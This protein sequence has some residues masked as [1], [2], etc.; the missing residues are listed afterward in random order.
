MPVF[1]TQMFGSGAVSAYEISKSCIFADAGSVVLTRTQVASPTDVKIWTFSCWIKRCNLNLS[2]GAVLLGGYD[3]GSGAQEHIAFS[4]GA[5]GAADTLNLYAHNAGA[6]GTDST[7][8]TNALFRDV[9][10]WYHLV[11]IK[12]TT[13]S[14]AANREKLYVNGVQQTFTGTSFPSLNF[15]TGRINLGSKAQYLCTW[16]NTV[17]NY[18]GYM[19]EA[20]FIDG[21]AKVVG[22]FGET[23]DDGVWIPI[24]YTGGSYGNN[25]F[26]LD[27]KSSGD[28]G[29]DVSGNNNDFSTT[30]MDAA[31]QSTDTPTDNHCTLNSADNLYSGVALSDG[32]KSFTNTAGAQHKAKGTMYPSSGKWYWEVKW[33]SG[34]SHG[35]VGLAQN[36]VISQWDMGDNRG[37]LTGESLGY[38]SYDGNTYKD[39]T[40][41][42]FGDSWT[43]GDIISVAWDADNGK[44][45]FGKNNTWQNSGDPTS[46]AT[47]TG[48]AYSLSS[49]V[50]AGGGWGPAVCNEGSSIFE[51]YFAE[52]EWSYSAPTGYTA[53]S[54]ANMAI[55]ALKDP[56]TNF[57]AAIYTG[58]GTAIG[59][60]GNAV[61][62]DGNS[63]MQP[64]IVWIKNRSAAD[65]HAN[66]DAARGVTKELHINETDAETTVAEGV[67]TFGSDGFTVGSDVGVN[68]NT[69][70]Y[71][72]WNWN[73]GNSGSSNTAGTI[74]T[75]T[76]YVDAT[77]GISVSTFEGNGTAGQTVGHGL[78]VKPDMII[79]KNRDGTEQWIVYHTA[80]GA[81]KY[82]L[83]N[84]NAA[85][86]TSNGAWNDV[87]PTTTLV[88][89]GGGGFGTNVSSNSMIMYAFAEVSGFSKFG[90]YT[91]NGSTDGPFFYCGFSPELI[92]V[93]R[94]DSTGYWGTWDASRETYNPR[95]DQLFFD[96]SNAEASN[97]WQIDFSANGAKIRDASAGINT[98]GG[99]YIFMAFA[100]NP[101]GGDGVA[102]ATAR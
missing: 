40:L 76:T 26:Y 52:A 81:T 27:F 50:T 35:Q 24:E 66:Y 67:T 92:A 91:G 97:D 3:S 7:L 36:D 61:T 11:V 90:I 83:L 51:C 34:S 49:T 48:S 93:K 8:I 54:T 16:Q 44:I 9:A 2:S 68:T 57:Q 20:H 32:N 28:L 62:F 84:S 56:S 15:A 4:N 17:V 79:I 72:S 88:T 87:E 59:S 77:A 29:N 42:T 85:F 100:I 10:A 60:G 74:N 45:Y 47:G 12:D 33:L 94:T 30:N 23:N 1:G 75:T 102:P 63:A 65:N 53:L 101:F 64:D 58:N 18:D 14:V 95:E 6:S 99:T 21:T 19:A 73:A 13:E 82:A 69:E 22:D 70:N 96:L 78:G 80:Q 38:R 41:A 39:S 89:L 25:G 71:V 43:T 46:G 37:D 98:S 5:G 86:A 31:D 55:P